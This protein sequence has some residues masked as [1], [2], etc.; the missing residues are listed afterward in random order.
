MTLVGWCCAIEIGN[1]VF[2][3]LVVIFVVPLPLVVVLLIPILA[4]VMSMLGGNCPV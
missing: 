2:V 4:V 3:A 1:L